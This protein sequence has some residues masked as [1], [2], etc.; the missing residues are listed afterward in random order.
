MKPLDQMTIPEKNREMC[1]YLGIHVCVCDA[2]NP[3]FATDPVWLLRE[4]RKGERFH[5]F[6]MQSWAKFLGLS[7]APQVCEYGVPI[8]YILNQ[9][10]LLLNAA[11]G[12]MRNKK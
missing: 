1:G 7:I 5:T 10:G 4:M 9:T 8:D 6:L 11:L 3:N 2:C 12:W